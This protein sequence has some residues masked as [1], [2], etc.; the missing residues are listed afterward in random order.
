MTVTYFIYYFRYLDGI[1]FTSIMFPSPHAFVSCN[2][3]Q[4]LLYFSA[5]KIISF[6]SDVF[7]VFLF[8]LFPISYYT[9]FCWTQPFPAN[10]FSLFCIPT[11]S[12]MRTHFIPSLFHW[13]TL[14]TIYICIIT[15]ISVI[16]TS[17]REYHLLSSHFK[18]KKI[19]C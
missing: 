12:L 17:C 7:S 10:Y 9:L 18:N 11:L 6:I 15:L 8:S 13:S 5:V 16:F 2:P 1:G 19:I 14:L 3:G 4:L